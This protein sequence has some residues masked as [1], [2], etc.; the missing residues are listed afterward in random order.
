MD[1]T[2]LSEILMFA[3][4]ERRQCVDIFIEDD[5]IPEQVESFFVA[6]EST[7]NLDGRITLEPVDGEIEILDANS[8]SCSP[9]AYVIVVFVFVV[10]VV[11]LERTLY[12]V[13]EDVGVVEVCAVVLSPSSPCPITFSFDVILVTND[14]SAGNVTLISHDTS[15]NLCCMYLQ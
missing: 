5:G 14:G 2:A 10:A 12:Q 6:L 11:G 8:M 7:P 13:S 15:S 4:C 1:Y 9:A 3:A